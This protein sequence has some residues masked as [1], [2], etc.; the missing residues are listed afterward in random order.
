MANYLTVGSKFKPFSM[1]EL[2][3][4]VQVATAEHTQSEAIQA[5]LGSKADMYK[6][7]IGDDPNSK[8]YQMYN[9]FIEDLDKQSEILSSE[10]VNSNNRRALLNLK[11][12]YSSNIVPI[13]EAD[14]KRK[15]LIEEQ[16]KLRAQ[17]NTLLFDR[18][19]ASVSIDEL[20]DNPSLSYTP[21][22]GATITKQVASAAQALAKKVN[23][24]PDKWKS[25][26]GGQY[27]EKNIKRGMSTEDIIKVI[28]GHPEGSKELNKIMDDV[29]SS[30]GISSW[31]N[32]EAL[33]TAYDYAKQGLWA[34]VGDT[35]TQQ[36]S[37]KEFDFN[38][39][40]RLAVAKEEAKRKAIKDSLRFRPVFNTSVDATKKTTELKED[41]DFI[42]ELIK[43][44]SLL[45]KKQK[46]NKID[47][48]IIPQSSLGIAI[49]SIM[50]TPITEEYSPYEERL[51]RLSEK[52]GINPIYKKDTDML[53]YTRYSNNFSDIAKKLDQNIKESAIRNTSYLI[54]LDDTSPIVGTIS[55]IID[56]RIANSNTD[57]TGLYEY[58][59]GKKGKEI[60]STEVGKYLQE[61]TGHIE[62][63]PGVGIILHSTVKGTNGD[64]E[65]F[66]TVL[67][68]ELLN[69]N[70]RTLSV[71]YLDPIEK[72]LKAKEYEL[73]NTFIV[74]DKEQNLTGIMDYL[75]DWILPADTRA[76]K[77][78]AQSQEED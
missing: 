28:E 1:A 50:H 36:M 19:A 41:L 38:Q 58:K 75:I 27:F 37:N 43:D 12:K 47:P 63:K 49:P 60:S 21:Y 61:G 52:Y 71:G 78:H 64:V 45:E 48:A 32:K 39:Q 70:I 55:N 51:A 8:A 15:A 62:Y 76:K 66:S 7:I 18:D 24:N 23:D 16:R 73:A 57:S 14:A 13:G 30:T 65:K 53:G 67:D 4:P 74:G 34:A 59:N 72:L 9:S 6:S 17:D 68:P 40:I 3:H 26:L 42:S 25:I 11:R 31:N 2:L 33:K 29:I 35:Q 54:D 46:R 10:G 20:I 44:P 56:S 22:S 77:L 5:E 69:D